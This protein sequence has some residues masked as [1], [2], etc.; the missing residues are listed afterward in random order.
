[1]VQEIGREKRK[2]KEKQ[3]FRVI[4]TLVNLRFPAESVRPAGPVGYPQETD[5]EGRPS[6]LSKDDLACVAVHRTSRELN[7]SLWGVSWTFVA[8]LAVLHGD[9][10]GLSSEVI[11]TYAL[12]VA[13]LYTLKFGEL[14]INMAYSAFSG[15]KSGPLPRSLHAL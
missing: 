14:L 13:I 10:T 5:L 1:M 2:K 12:S 7:D 8:S 4:D 15:D 11:W 3:I 9:H 6:P